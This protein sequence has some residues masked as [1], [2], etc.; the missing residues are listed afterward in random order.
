MTWKKRALSF[1]VGVSFVAAGGGLTTASAQDDALDPSVPDEMEES[2]AEIEAEEDLEDLEEEDLDEQ[3]DELLGEDEDD[4]RPWSITGSWGLSVGQGTF[5]RIA[6]DSQWADQVHD[7]SGAYNRVSMNLGLSP[8]YRWNDF[9]FGGR[10]GISQGLTAGG[11]I[12]RPYETRLSDVSLSAGWSGH[13]FDAIGV[14]VRPSLGL[15]LPTSVRS[16][17]TTLL[18]GTSLGLGFSKNFFQ[19]LTLSYS[20]RA[21]R[22]FYRFTSPVVEVDRIGEENAIFRTGGAEDVQPGRFAVG[23]VNTPWSLSN[24]V[25]ASFRVGRV[26]STVTY[27]YTR[28]WSYAWTEQDEFTSDFQCVGRCV[29][30]GMSGSISLGYSLN[31]WLSMSA[32][33]SSGGTPKTSDQRS[34]NFPFW[35]FNG[36]A[37]GGS[38]LSLG[39]SGRY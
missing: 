15:T 39:L 35:N 23:G 34:F 26:S 14:S 22:S 19:A 3:L 18:A 31:D 9:S 37:G 21:G 8:S 20:V 12:N 25:S 16:Q 38:S 28:R 17:H 13:T 33:L 2:L 24:S 29:G 36:A 30:D 1:V 7:G 27:A 6:N 32:G 4:A 11:G 5:A 10:I